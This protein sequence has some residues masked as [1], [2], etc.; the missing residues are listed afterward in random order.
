MDVVVVYTEISR[1]QENHLN[2]ENPVIRKGPLEKRMDTVI[3]VGIT[4][5]CL[6]FLQTMERN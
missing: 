6:Q 2:T 3:N 1:Q 5:M 4:R